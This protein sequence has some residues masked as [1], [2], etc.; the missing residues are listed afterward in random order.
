MWYSPIVRVVKKDGSMQL[1][2]DYRR[3]SEC[4]KGLPYAHGSDCRCLF[5]QHSSVFGLMD[6]V[7]RPHTTYAATYLDDVIIHTDTWT[8]HVQQVAT[9]LQCLRSAGLTVNPKECAVGWRAVQYLEYHWGGGQV[10]SQMY[11]TAAIAS[12]LRKILG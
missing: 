3:V 12:C 10:S 7:L 1:C 6:I 5:S 2:V 4:S 11:N 8:K 9:V